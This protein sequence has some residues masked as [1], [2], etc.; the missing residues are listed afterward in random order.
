[1]SLNPIKAATSISESYFS[2]LTTTFRFENEELQRQFSEILRAPDRFTKGPILQITPDYQK[3]LSV[4]ELVNKGILSKKFLQIKSE[5]LPI[6]RPLYLHQQKAICKLVQDRRNLVVATGTGS[7]K[8]ETFMLPIINDLL[9]E[10]EHGTIS[11]GVRALLLYPMNALANDQVE[12]LRLL[13]ANYPAITFGRYTGETRKNTKEAQEKYKAIHGRNPLKNELISRQEMWINPPHILLTNYAMLEYLLLRPQDNVFFDGQFAQHWR[14][15]VIDEAHT[16]SGAKG[17]E[18]AML[19]R[20]LKDRITSKPSSGV[21]VIATSATLGDGIK[22]GPEIVEFASHLFGERFEWDLND[23]MKQD[24]VYAEINPLNSNESGW[25]CPTP[26]KY[27]EWQNIIHNT[28]SF[29]ISHEL[30]LS[31]RNSLMPEAILEK[32]KKEGELHGWQALLYEILKGDLNLKHLQNILQTSPEDLHKIARMLFKG[33]KNYGESLVALVDIAQSARSGK[34]TQPLLPARYHMFVRA[35]EGAYLSLLPTPRL[36]MERRE[37]V[38]IDN[39]AYPVFEVATCRNCGATY[40]VGR[41]E[42]QGDTEFFKQ[43]IPEKPEEYYLVSNRNLSVD[44]VD[45]DDEIV[46][47]E[48]QGYADK[49]EQFILCAACGAI[50]PEQKVQKLCQCTTNNYVHLIHATAKQRDVVFT[51]PSCGKRNPHGM[52][53]RFL[54]GTDATAS[55]L[56]TSLYQNIDSDEL[57]ITNNPQ[58]QISS[59][60]KWSSTYAEES[61][62]NDPSVLKTND[63][64]KLLAFSDNRQDAAFFAPYFNRTYE[65]L[66]R[67]S[68][69]LKTLEK[70]KQQV[71]EY[72]WTVPDLIVPLINYA[73]EASFF[74]NNASMQNK[75]DQIWK[76]LLYEL[77]GFDQRINLE[78][79]GLL[80]FA[81]LKPDRWRAPR[82]LMQFPW[83]LSEEE[84]WILFA[85]L[86]NTLRKQGVVLFPEHILPKDEFFQPRNREYFIRASSEGHSRK[87]GILSWNPTR[88]NSR[89]DYLIRLGNR[90]S[91]N[92]TKNGCREVLKNIYEGLQLLNNNSCWQNL[93]VTRN[94]NNEGVVFQLRNDI[95]QLKPTLIDKSVQ[96]YICDRCKTLT[97]YNLRNVCPSYRCPGTLKPCQPEELLTSNHYFRLYR[98]MLPHK[99]SASEHTA[100]LTTQAAAELQ[101]QFKIG[102]INVLSCSTTFELGVDVGELEAVFLRNVPPSAANYIQR[103]GRAGRRADTTAFVLTFAQRRSHDLDHFR[104]PWRIVNGKIGTPHFKLENLK[105][106]NRHMNAVALALFW[107]SHQEYFGKVKDFFC[108]SNPTSGFEEFSSYLKEHPKELKRSLQNIV[109]DH[110]HIIL[111]INEWSWIDHLFY[112]DNAVLGLAREKIVGDLQELED[113]RERNFKERRDIRHLDRLINTLENKNLINYMSSNNIL[114]KY[115]FPVDVVELS[116]D[117]HGFDGEGVQ[118]ERDL[119]IALSEYAPESQVVARGKLWTSRYLRRIPNKEWESYRYAICD[120]CHNYYSIRRELEDELK[121]C[122]A[123]QTTFGINKG[124]FIIPTY[125]FL[126]SRDKPSS[127]GQQKPEKTYTTRVYFADNS[128]LTDKEEKSQNEVKKLEINFGNVQVI[129]IPSFHGKLAVI[130]N[131]G[132]RRFKVC[133][134][135]GYTV[136]GNAKNIPHPHSTQWGKECQGKLYSNLALGHEFTTDILRLSFSGYNNPD[137]GFWFSLLYALLEGTSTVLDIERQ[138]IDG[139]L[140]YADMSPQ[141]IFFDDVPG[142]AGH[143]H[144]MA[145]R[146]RL[147]DILKVSLQRLKRCECGGNEDQASCYG[148]LRNYR[149][150]FCHDKLDRHVVIDFLEDLLK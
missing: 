123:C 73:E 1:M 88:L 57:Q 5:I 65:Q 140:Y 139:C 6:D 87:R 110:L 43:P 41:T 4:A 47:S 74:A 129:A 95:W 13:L 146:Q 44:E 25:G 38:I 45:E 105:I 109:P 111:G 58:Q 77:L 138:D 114:P 145:Q 30:V 117:H 83:N 59:D 55:V 121:I 131:A 99:M 56:A 33:Q 107:N 18:T 40:L 116:L 90:I 135:C 21:Q 113:I 128:F 49:L 81:L 103:A 8:T 22:V 28:P 91:P 122:P 75:V 14:Y 136:L 46:F 124:V 98:E 35:I 143:V 69:I 31:A 29:N 71:L 97:I 23:N 68:L 78:G 134:N 150:Q 9:V 32:A 3:G 130:N 34:N 93:F 17:I 72:N 112:G 63:S 42:K 147:L 133:Y 137:E 125:G 64:R 89:L 102:K 144:R 36:Y 60:N 100:Q 11:S 67:R 50:K 10:Q 48:L 24:V 127:P 53:R 52:V 94:L 19:L 82:P 27:I 96:W 118:L 37:K 54:T 120:N 142:G 16:F 149:N 80:G 85:V 76:W 51:C 84:V 62:T 108:T 141:L 79:M 70:N 101:D 86:I 61:N 66:L 7:G 12:R 92:I 115:G 126:A 2:Y 132:K 26:S 106:I 15:I 20:R 104:E 148:C 39:H 119:R